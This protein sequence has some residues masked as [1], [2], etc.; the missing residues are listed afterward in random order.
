MGDHLASTFFQFG[1]NNRQVRQICQL[2]WNLDK[3]RLS[4]QLEYQMDNQRL[5]VSELGTF[6]HKN[7]EFGKS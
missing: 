3:P 5:L 2:N 7:A 4:D 6:G 1:R